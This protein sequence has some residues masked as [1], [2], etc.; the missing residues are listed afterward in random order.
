MIL[1]VALWN[2]FPVIKREIESYE[3]F[4]EVQK[5]KVLTGKS[6]S[7]P[8]PSTKNRAHLSVRDNFR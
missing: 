7:I 3:N 4:K 1:A 2:I 6:L 8:L 5:K